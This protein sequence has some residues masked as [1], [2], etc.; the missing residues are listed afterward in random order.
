METISEGSLMKGQEWRQSLLAVFIAGIWSGAIITLLRVLLS[1]YFS[2]LPYSF[3]M[4][5]VEAGVACNI[6][7]WVRPMVGEPKAVWALL[8]GLFAQSAALF[9]FHVGHLLPYHWTA[10]VTVPAAWIGMTLEGT[11]KVIGTSLDDGGQT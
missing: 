9:P 2:W 11:P 3:P 4:L 10:L 6:A 7:F 5:I 8:L 1:H